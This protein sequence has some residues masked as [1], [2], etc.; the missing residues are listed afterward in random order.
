MSLHRVKQKPAREAPRPARLRQQLGQVFVLPWAP[1][2]TAAASQTFPRRAPWS[3]AILVKGRG[4]GWGGTGKYPQ[5]RRVAYSRSDQ[6]VNFTSAPSPFSPRLRVIQP[7]RRSGTG[8]SVSEEVRYWRGSEERVELA[9][10]AAPALKADPD[11][12]IRWVDEWKSAGLRVY[13]TQYVC[14]SVWRGGNTVMS[15]ERHQED[16]SR[17]TLR[18][19]GWRSNCALCLFLLSFI[20]PSIHSSVNTF[21]LWAKHLPV[22]KKSMPTH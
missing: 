12:P 5:R 1:R 13:E 16:F 11:R 3:L 2:R 17:K 10:V 15:A 22:K 20:H 6:L 4:G 18:L 14:M 8:R 9:Q 21:A 19:K 7:L